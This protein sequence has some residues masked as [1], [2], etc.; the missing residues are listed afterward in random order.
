MRFATFALSTALACIG[1][2]A[3]SDT[4]QAAIHPDALRLVD[5]LTAEYKD[6]LLEMLSG[7]SAEK[8]SQWAEQTKRSFEHKQK[9]KAEYEL[10]AS[11]EAMEFV[12]RCLV[13]IKHRD[14]SVF[15]VL[16]DVNTLFDVEK[17][18]TQSG[19]TAL[20]WNKLFGDFSS[21]SDEQLKAFTSM[22]SLSSSSIYGPIR[23]VDTRGGTERVTEGIY[24]S[25][26]ANVKREYEPVFNDSDEVHF[27]VY[28]IDGEFYWEPFNW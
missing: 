25:I 2:F 10:L 17:E 23:I 6:H 18:L 15:K 3:E 1:L 20:D 5:V 4:E 14:R 21:L 12:S 27:G 7:M 24:R 11:H 26:T 13:K 19:V 22:F 8:Q 16:T 9:H 28:L